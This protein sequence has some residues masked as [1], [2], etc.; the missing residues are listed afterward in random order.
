MSKIFLLE[1]DP[2]LG[3]GIVLQLELE[4]YEVTWATSITRAK[5]L[6]LGKEFDLFILDVNLPDGSGFDFAK[7]LKETGAKSPVF[8]LTAR[9][10]EESVVHGFDLG[11]SDYVK[12]PFGNRELLARVRRHLGEKRAVSEMLRYG[13]LTL[14]L[15]QQALKFKES[16]VALNRREFDLLQA[17]F[18]RPETVLS[19]ETLL[20]K[21]GTGDEIYDRTI[22]SHISHIRARFKKSKIE[23]YRI[24]SVYGSGYRLERA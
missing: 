9:T 17:F 13:E 24:A 4:S 18:E 7:W 22:D 10:D 16:V 6:S 23:S 19:R 1:D 14:L 11:A 8:F 15:D 21:L 2:S 20:N 12:K 3:R 5:E